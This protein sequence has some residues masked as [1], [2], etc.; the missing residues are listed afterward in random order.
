MDDIFHLAGG[1]LATAGGAA[2]GCETYAFNPPGVHPNTYKMYGVKNPNTSK[3]HTYYSNQDFLNM[4]NNNLALMP[5]SAGERIQ[6]HTSDKFGFATGHDLPLL[7]KAIEAE[8]GKQ[9][10]PIITNDL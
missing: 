9:G 2:T 4:G 5:N 8:Q 10:T 3:V 7:L 6:M 1:G